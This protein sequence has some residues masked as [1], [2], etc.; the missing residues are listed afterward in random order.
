MYRKVALN[1][2]KLEKMTFLGFTGLPELKQPIQSVSRV[3]I[4]IDL[5][6]LKGK[7]YQEN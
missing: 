1:A 3:I 2:T 6:R 4:L 7:R 5:K